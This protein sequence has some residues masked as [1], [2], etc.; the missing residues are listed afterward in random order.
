[1]NA[2]SI[3]LPAVC[4]CLSGCVVENAS[5]PIRHE[6]RTIERDTAENARMEL[7]MGAGELRVE[8]GAAPLMQADFNYNV[9]A[10]KPEIS[11]HSFA[12]RADLSIRQPAGAGH[13]GNA[14]YD[15][16]LRL[17]ND[18]PT[19][20][21]LHF[22]AGEAHLDLG[23]LNLRSVEVEMGVGEIH[24][25]L[26]GM[27]KHDYNVRIRGGI[28]EATVNLPANAGIY[29]KAEGGLGEI[30]V[31]GLRQENGRWLNE[32]Y[33]SDRP[34]IRVDVRGGIGQINLIAE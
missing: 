28:G 33:D 5:G 2:K 7:R 14:K 1:M 30:Q 15:W 25:D 24:V 16:D 32:W 9:P 10:W 6:T 4:A 26:R 19:D 29:A 3:L 11:Y 23:S 22:G 21:V 12:G 18:I 31:R 20:F 8:G 13:I 27:P 34:Q 17:N